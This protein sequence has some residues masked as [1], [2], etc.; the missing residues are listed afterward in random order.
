[1]LLNEK[2]LIEKYDQFN[3]EYFNNDIKGYVI[4]NFHDMSPQNML[5]R[6]SRKK[7]V[8]IKNK[9]VGII[10]MIFLN[11]ILRTIDIS[12]DA[13]DTILVHEMIHLYLM[14]YKR[15][16]KIHGH[17]FRSECRRIKKINPK[18]DLTYYDST[19]LRKKL[20]PNYPKT[21]E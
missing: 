4:I 16:I 7:S 15:K 21:T 11:N 2:I 18:L 3:K 13:I 17:V 10:N 12:E 9:E 1:M 14:D 20:L 19:T 8:S 6:V 5:G